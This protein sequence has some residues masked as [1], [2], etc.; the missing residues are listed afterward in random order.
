MKKFFK[1]HKKPIKNFFILFS[2]YIRKNQKNKE[3]RQKKARERYQSLS[4]EEK[5]KKRNYGHER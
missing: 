1:V 2:L 5:N 3:R 4:E